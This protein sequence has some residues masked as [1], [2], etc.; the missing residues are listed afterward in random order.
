MTSTSHEHKERSSR[1]HIISLAQTLE[2]WVPRALLIGRMSCGMTGSTAA[3][4]ASMMSITP[5]MTHT[6]HCTS[7][8]AVQAILS[9]T[10]E[11][12]GN[13]HMQ[14][15]FVMSYTCRYGWRS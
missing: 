2:F 3:P 13:I 1:G 7:W 9:N 5:C 4:C 8:M 11:H 6:Y 15:T 12:A 14:I 10:Y